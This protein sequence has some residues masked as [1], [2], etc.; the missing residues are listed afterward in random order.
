[1]DDKQKDFF[2]P[3]Y[4][5]LMTAL[6]AVVLVLFIMSYFNFKNK[7]KQL[8]DM[9][10]IYKPDAEILNKVKANLKLFETDKGIF[11]VDSLHNRIQ[12]A[13][14]IKYKMGFEFFDI[15]PDH[16]DADYKITTEKLDTLG[17][18]LQN[19]ILRFQEQKYSDSTM[20][21]IS[22]LLVISGSASH[23]GDTYKNYVLSYQRALS[24][25]YYWKDNLKIDFDSPQFQNIIELQIAGIGTGGVG[26]YNIPFDPNNRSEEEKNQRFIIYIAPKIMK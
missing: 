18:K 19:I 7:E 14:D 1:M 8:E 26:R 9:V 16:I 5:D 21:D 10:Q 25:Y 6:F 2:W 12:I 3:S 20:K 17:T 15:R 11:L 23:Y 24:L 13:F 4:V 22:Y